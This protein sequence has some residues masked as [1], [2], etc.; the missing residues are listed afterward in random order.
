[1]AKIYLLVQYLTSSEESPQSSL[2]SQNRFEGMQ[3]PLPQ[4]NSSCLH[5]SVLTVAW[6]NP[7]RMQARINSRSA[8]GMTDGISVTGKI[9]SLHA[10][11]AHINYSHIAEKI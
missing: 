6:R 3:R 5:L 2:L 7:V 10:L 8:V 11:N 1:M 4:A 9:Q